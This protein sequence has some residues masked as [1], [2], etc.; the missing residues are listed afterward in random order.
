M[1]SLYLLLSLLIATTTFAEIPKPKKNTYVNDFAGVLKPD[2]I[3]ALNKQI[4]KIERLSSVQLA[5]VLVN[6]IP[7]EYQIEDYALLIGR[8]W[9]VGKS[10][11][12]LVYV[13]AI[14]Q[15]KQRLEVARLLRDKLSDEQC[16]DILT[17]MKPLFRQQDYN[18]GLNVMV[19]K[20]TYALD[21]AALQSAVAE[22]TPQPQKQKI[23][24]APEKTDPAITLIA[25]IMTWGVLLG[26]PLLIVYF[27][28][29]S[30][31]RRLQREAAISQMNLMN[32]GGYP[33]NGPI[34][35][36]YNNGGYN[37]GGYNNG[38]SNSGI[39]SNVGSFVA[40]AATGYA[41]RTIQDHFSDRGQTNNSSNNQP[42]YGQPATGGDYGGSVSSSDNN[43]SDYGNWDSGSSDSGSS[44]DSSSDSGF[45]GDSG[46][47]SNW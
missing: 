32:Y 25:T 7:A 27:M 18:G 9:H 41:A 14:S 34:N 20:L 45:D 33:T 42:S 21:P 16:A 12:G 6:K 1:K 44:S 31:R 43:S 30:R 47:T 46:A 35:N 2:E 26:I 39:G 13:A 8:K 29:D 19:N 4:H 10:K 36:G 15:H 24:A 5:I 28:Y 3:K 40:G 17:A 11:N 22:Q 38:R 23:A 37:N